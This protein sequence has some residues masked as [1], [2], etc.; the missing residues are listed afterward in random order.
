MKN[1]SSDPNIRFTNL[2]IGVDAISFFP[3]G[4]LELPMHH[5][6][7][8]GYDNFGLPYFEDEEGNQYFYSQLL[9]SEKKNVETPA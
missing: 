8:I 4:K 7:C 3:K 1:F 9:T 5:M 6:L 2:Q